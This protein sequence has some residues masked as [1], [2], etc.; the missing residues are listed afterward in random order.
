MAISPAMMSRFSSQFE[1][2]PAAELHNSAEY[3]NFTLALTRNGVS[4]KTKIIKTKRSGRKFV[5]ILLGTAENRYV[6]GN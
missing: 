1:G 6:V 4:F 3:H 5:V 2:L